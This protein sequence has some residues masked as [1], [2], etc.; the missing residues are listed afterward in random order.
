MNANASK[1]TIVMLCDA[2]HHSIN[3]V[4]QVGA[5]GLDFGRCG[6]VIMFDLPKNVVDYM[7]VGGVRTWA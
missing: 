3:V 1:I 2:C 7:Q 4:V 6:L 5:E